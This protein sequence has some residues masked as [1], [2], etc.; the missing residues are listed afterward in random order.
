MV[1]SVDHQQVQAGTIP[2]ENPPFLVGISL[3]RQKLCNPKRPSSSYLICFCPDIYPTYS[4]NYFFSNYVTLYSCVFVRR[5]LSVADQS[6][7]VSA[8]VNHCLRLR[9][10]AFCPIRIHW[11]IC[12]LRLFLTTTVPKWSKLYISSNS[13][14]FHFSFPT[15]ELFPLLLVSSSHWFLAS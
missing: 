5:I 3:V 2:S 14:V 15:F 7:P 6:W 11:S 9:S 1:T 4:P 12:L 10:K 8:S 13:N